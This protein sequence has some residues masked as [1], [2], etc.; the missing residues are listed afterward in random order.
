M[1]EIDSSPW[2]PA[3]SELEQVR[4]VEDRYVFPGENDRRKEN[5]TNAH[6]S[7]DEVSEPELIDL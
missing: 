3:P 2:L 1:L 6:Y 7:D 5:D 4:Q